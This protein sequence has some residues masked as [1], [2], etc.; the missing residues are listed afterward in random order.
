MGVNYLFKV[1]IGTLLFNFFPLLSVKSQVIWE[2]APD[3]QANLK[4]NKTS[5]SENKLSGEYSYSFSDPKEI[6]NSIDSQ[7]DWK[8]VMPELRNPSTLNA[9]IKWE[10]LPLEENQKQNVPKLHVWEEVP[11]ENN[12]FNDL[13]IKNDYGRIETPQNFEEAQ[14]ILSRLQP[15]PDDYQLPLSLGLAVPT[16]NQLIGSDIRLSAFQISPF[17]P[18]EAG[19]TGN[20]NYAMYMDLGLT[21][22][23][24]M[25]FFVSQADDPLYAKLT[26]FGEQPANFWESYGAEFKYRLASDRYG[27]YEDAAGRYWNLSI[28]A[29]IEGWNVGSGGCDSAQCQGQ[30]DASPNI[31]NDSGERVFTRNLIGSLKLPFSWNVSPTWQVTVAPGASF[32]PSMQG[33]GQG[34]AGDF[35]GHSYWISG[36]AFWRPIPVV[37][38]FGSALM[39]L[40]PGDNSFDENLSF[41]KVPVLTA[42]LSWNLNPRIALE[43]T[44]SNGW[45]ATPATAFL[46]LPSSDQIG[47]STK[48][49]YTSGAADTPQLP[50]TLRQE[51]L[52]SGGLTVNTALVPPDGTTQSWVNLDSGGNLFG[53][54]SHSLS[55]IFQLDLYQAGLFSQ[56]NVMGGDP[57][58]SLSDNYTT[59]AGLHWRVGGK[60]VALSPLRGAPLWTSGRISLGRN[61]DAKSYQGYIFAESI[62]TWEAN[63]WLA[64]NVNPK[65]ALSGVSDPW[66]IGISANLQIGESFQLIPEVNLVGSHLAATNSTFAL[67]WLANPETIYVDF[68]LSNAAGLM[69]IGQLMRVNETRI[70]GKVSIV[71]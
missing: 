56:V 71:F 36:G 13:E 55:N 46:T 65:I 14:L 15:R 23:F 62:N 18:G 50:L 47:Y 7:D 44:L 58:S 32:L 3:K 42:G 2:L 59:D 6:E 19:G 51:S 30:D 53:S 67:R 22:R 1:L 45:G 54:I 61:N 52:A 8:I 12:P 60:A 21:D 11:N 39:P 57:S 4:P 40:G 64:F 29:S 66:G 9:P 41:E 31:F 27:L 35:Y 37:E 34:G 48:F 24:Q 70:G 63:E 10:S 20:Q 28:T 33:G 49:V 43:G 68:Y 26:G 5:G 16:A 25:S 38:M 69:D 17:D